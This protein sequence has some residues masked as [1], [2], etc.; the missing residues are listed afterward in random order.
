M[1][2]DITYN[3]PLRGAGSGICSLWPIFEMGD[4]AEEGDQLAT[5]PDMN[6]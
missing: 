6:V 2:A 1:F 3:C 5:G 4:D